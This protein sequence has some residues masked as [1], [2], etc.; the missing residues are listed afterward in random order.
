[1]MKPTAFVINTSRG[2]V[3][4]ERRWCALRRTTKSPAPVSMSRARAAGFLRAGRDA[5]RGVDPHLGSAVLSLREA[6]LWWW[7][8]PLLIEGNRR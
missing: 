6:A 7:I 5:G 2:P 4:D 3:I 8:T 1:M